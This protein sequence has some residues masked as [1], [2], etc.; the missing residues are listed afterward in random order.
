MIPHTSH[1]MLQITTSHVRKV[2][3]EGDDVQHRVQHGTYHR[4]Y[5]SLQRVRS[6]VLH[7]PRCI[8]SFF[9]SAQGGSAVCFANEERHF[10]GPR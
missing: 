9:F 3:R 1:T 7:M 6:M 4:L 5:A 8:Y 10:C 2:I